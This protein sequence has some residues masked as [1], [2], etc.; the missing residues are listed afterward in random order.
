MNMIDVFNN[1]AFA[2]TS[3]SEALQKVYN[4]SL[5]IL[6]SGLFTA[7]P[8][9]TRS[10]IMDVKEHHFNILPLQQVGEPIPQRSFKK[11]AM[12]QIPTYRIGEGAKLM[13]AEL[14]FLRQ[15]GTPDE[16]VAAAVTE[17][18]VR[19]QALLTDHDATLEYMYLNALDGKV[20]DKDGT[21]L[22]D[23]YDLFDL[24]RPASVALP[25][26]TAKDGDLRELIE[27]QICIK[28]E[29]AAAGA[30]FSTI[31]ASCG[32]DA[33]FALMKNP[34]FR[35]LQKIAENVAAM[36][37]STRNVPVQFAGVNWSRYQRDAQGKISLPSDKVKFYPSGK[38]NTV[39]QDVMAPGETFADLGKY[40]SPIY[41]RI[42]PDTKRDSYVELE[43]M[44]Y[45][46]ALCTR[47]E[48]LR[49]GHIL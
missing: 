29:D 44:S 22:I 34:E 25:L 3:M 28:I 19:Q 38:G 7:K 2:M 30:Q 37:G 43:V 41:S 42:I 33:W 16:M 1:D 10:F 6:K 45:R 31:D 21:V 17:V 49:S 32:E 40:G 5:S 4:P 14:A 46:M 23:M 26:S 12:T 27:R 13:A 36:G 8:I 20:V 9:N 47:P 11:G 24:S 15:F 35:E 48:T 18:A 39:F